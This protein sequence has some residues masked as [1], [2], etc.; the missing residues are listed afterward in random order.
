[1]TSLKPSSGASGIA[2]VS[3]MKVGSWACNIIVYP[4]WDEWVLHWVVV[5]VNELLI[6]KSIL[7]PAQFKVSL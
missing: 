6:A 7:M 3:L 2:L 1:M 4:C 5:V